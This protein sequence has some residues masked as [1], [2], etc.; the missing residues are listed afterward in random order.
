MNRYFK[1][2][3]V[4]SLLAGL[5]WPCAG[6]AQTTDTF[7]A[8]INVDGVVQGGGSGYGGGQW[9]HYPNSGWYNQWFYD[10]PF[11]ANGRKTIEYSAVLNTLSP[12]A[13]G[14]VTVAINWT[15]DQWQDGS[16]P[17]LPG[18]FANNPNLESQYITRQTV[19]DSAVTGSIG[20][21]GSF[22]IPD[23]YCP[24]WVSVD[25]KG[26][27]VKLTLGSIT[28]SCSVQPTPAAGSFKW[29]QPPIEY[30]PRALTSVFCGWDEP[31]YV[32]TPATTA[33]TVPNWKLVADDFRCIGSMPITSV[34]WWGSYSGWA[35]LNSTPSPAPSSWLLGFWSNVP[36][37]GTAFSHPGRVLQV[38]RVPAG[39]VSITPAGIDRFSGKSSDTC[40]KY[41]VD[42][43]A[44]QYFWQDKYLTSTADNVF[45]LSI[46]AI[47]AG[48]QTTKYPWGWKTRPAHWMD[49]AVTFSALASDIPVGYQPS[50]NT[51]NPIQNSAVC[52]QA[53]SYDMC[54]ALDTL[55][56]YVKW[57]Q[58]FTGLDDWPHYEDQ[59][60]VATLTQASSIAMKWQQLP[61]LKSTGVDMD[62]TEDSPATWPAEI[63]ADD[64]QCTIPGPLTG[65]DIWG[66]WYFDILP[67]GD[68]NNVEFTLSIHKDVPA[69][70]ATVAGYSRPGVV[71]WSKTFAPG[72]VTVSRQ[73]AGPES[74][75][76]PILNFYL[77]GSDASV[78]RYHFDINSSEAFNQTGTAASPVTY[79]L[80]VQAHLTRKAGGCATRWG[81]KTSV[82]QWNDMPVYAAGT[83][84]TTAAW[85]MLGYP[86]TH[87]YAGQKVGLAFQLTTSDQSGG[88]TVQSQVAD[89]WKCNSRNPITAAVWWGSYP[90]YNYQ[91]CACQT[92][93]DPI[94]PSYFWLSIWTDVPATVS[95]TGAAAYSH[96]GRLVWEYNAYNYDEVLV[97]FD[98]HPEAVA[99]VPTPPGFEPVYRYSV[100]IPR[101]NW[102]YQ[103]G[104]G[105]IYW[106]SVVAVYPDASAPYTWGWTNHAHAFNDDAVTTVAPYLAPSSGNLIWTPL[107]DQTRAS[108][109]MSFTLFTDPLEFP[110]N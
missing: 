81:W 90:G 11:N 80:S 12:T 9:Y 54:F 23:N 38:V 72:H 26:V 75:Y 20:I 7:N 82:S 52:Q 74:F 65:I 4:L 27:N 31:A 96:P 103:P 108:E 78:Y 55:A 87:P 25:I 93:K 94:R 76:H 24:T 63:L 104:A 95:T 34:H 73:D 88:L 71:L 29:E 79:W 13:G 59:P 84:A 68:A 32:Y 60:S 30:D 2:T 41:A 43:S 19:Y 101:A 67:D 46:T 39:Q 18:Q 8:T 61:D 102:F 64:F 77:P 14:R 66:S 89:D 109:D 110:P 100:S 107:Y 51:M 48:N 1:T 53:A 33:G 86:S 57:D 58:P 99:T 36:A 106:F 49:D 10:G 40:Y 17:P 56:S 28:H 15:T 35:E 6:L 92:M 97:G 69:P 70:P 62:A 47:Y 3:A 83:D 105:T 45:W 85:K 21:G 98:K 5:I 22:D 42:L 91:S 37:T 16:T 44:D 50:A